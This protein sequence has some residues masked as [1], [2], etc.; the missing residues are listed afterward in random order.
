MEERLL[1]ATGLRVSAIGL[2]TL[3]WGRDTDADE[4]ATQLRELVDAGGSFL[5]TAASYGA[6]EA[7]LVV[8]ALLGSAVDRA[9][10]V[11]CTKGGIRRTR[12]GA[13]VDAS[14][15]SLLDSLDGSLARLG[16][17]HVD[18]FLVQQPDARTPAGEVASTLAHV[19]STGRARYVGVSNHP[20]WRTVRV[21]DLLAPAPLAAVEVE[22][23]LLQRGVEREVVPAAAD[24]GAGVLAW[25]PLGRG[26][27]TGKYRRTVPADSRAASAH[28]AGF[29]E[30]YLAQRRAPVVE[31]LVTAADGLGRAPAEVAMAWVLSRGVSCAITG[32][33]TVGQLRPLLTMD[34]ELPAAILAALDEVS[35]PEL[36]YPERP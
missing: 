29:V 35:A 33:R 3:T 20:A 15:R 6:G 25:S 18:L 13:V 12:A 14:R 34:P 36:G 4:A 9:D 16:T 10:V 8:G 26:V 21:A 28:L 32:A 2:G 19:L 11:L 5:D 31:A 24:V 27:L 23:S 1:G 22:Y 7:E 30:P 17:D